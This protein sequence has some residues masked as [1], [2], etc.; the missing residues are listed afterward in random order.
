[1]ISSIQRHLAALLVAAA[2]SAAVAQTLPLQPVDSFASIA[3]RAERSRALFTEAGKV[4][5][6]PRCM[7]CHPAGSRPS[8][9]ADMHPHLP[10]V[11]R[12]RDDK[13]SGAL[14]CAT[15]HQA[16][17]YPQAGIPGHALWHLAPIS[18]AWQTRSLPQICEQIKDR[19]RNGGKSLA[20]LHEHMAHDPLVGWAWNPGAGR[21]PAPGTQEAFGQ[22]I[23]AW[24]ETG[25]ACPK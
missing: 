21:E 11:T 24:I 25:A 1:M 20:Q 4:I 8:Q 7:N 19:Q 15:C 10:I 6:S 22:L 14:P 5:Q 16:V 12:G 17:N 23:A 18:M 13:G 3:D 2:S 9:G